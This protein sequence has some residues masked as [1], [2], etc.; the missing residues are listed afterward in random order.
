M[1]QAR[2]WITAVSEMAV[3]LIKVIFTSR[4]PMID[5]TNPHNSPAQPTAMLEL[6]NPNYG[7]NF[8]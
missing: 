4:F 8:H 2:I 1:S 3:I 5:S 7:K 6:S